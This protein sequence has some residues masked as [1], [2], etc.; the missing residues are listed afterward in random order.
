MYL[1]NV[2]ILKFKYIKF[3]YLYIYIYTLSLNQREIKGL[4]LVS[5][6]VT[7]LE[8]M[9]YWY[10][11]VS[12]YNTHLLLK[13][14]FKN[15]KNWQIYPNKLLLKW[16]MLHYTFY[17][18]HKNPKVVKKWLVL[19]MLSLYFSQANSTIKRSN[20]ESRKCVHFY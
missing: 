13:S 15:F 10:N 4:A 16:K 12:W 7:L 19:L 5:I 3:M 14:A 1:K 6:Q 17:N 2:V 20:N 9:S 18:K 8:K 11:L